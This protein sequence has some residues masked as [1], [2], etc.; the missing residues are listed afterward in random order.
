MIHIVRR[1]LRLRLFSNIKKI[2]TNF[3]IIS[4][5]T[6]VYAVVLAV[7]YA[8]WNYVGEGPMYEYRETMLR[9]CPSTWFA[10]YQNS[11]PN[12]ILFEIF[13]WQKLL[14]LRTDD[15]GCMIWTW[16]LTHDMQFY[17]IASPILALFSM[18]VEIILNKIIDY[19]KF[20]R[21]PRC[22]VLV[23]ISIIFVSVVVTTWR[24]WVKD[25][26]Y[27]DIDTLHDYLPN[28]TR[29]V[30]NYSQLRF[31]LFPFQFKVI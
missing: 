8:I 23:C 2:L 13:R 7:A 20:S 30:L 25:L 28:S 6:P 1:Y 19:F 24:I 10:G 15:P 5:L 12:K 14:Y 27:E 22:G 21:K 29:F 16:Y 26:Q 18:S 11:Q 4:R 9:A 3:S 17:W 31:N